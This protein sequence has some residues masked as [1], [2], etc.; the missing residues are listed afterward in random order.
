MAI[1]RPFRGLRPRPEMAQEVASPPYDVLSTEEARQIARNNRNSFLRV[2]KAELEFNGETD[3]YSESVYRRSKE[4]LMRLCNDGI[5]IRD[6]TPSFYTYRLTMNNRRQTG[7]VAL[8]S[9]DEYDHGKIKKHEHTRPEKVRDRARHMEYLEA[10]VGPVLTTFKY[11][12]KIDFIFKR[13]TTPSALTDF[14][15]DDNVRHELWVVN[16]PA[17][18]DEII[19]A[20]ADVPEIYIADGHHRSAS[21]SEVRRRLQEKNADHRGDEIYNFFLTVNFPDQELNILPYN[22]VVKNLNDLTIEQ[23]LQKTSEKFDVSRADSE[24]RPENPHEFGVYCGGQWFLLKARPGSFDESS[25]AG[26]IDASILATNLITPILGIDNP[27]TDPRIDFV[28]GIRGTAEL[29]KRVDSG[30]YKIAFSLYPTSIGQLLSV[31]DAGEVMPPKSTWFEPKLRSGM[32]VNM[33]TE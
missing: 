5:M 24:I 13:I 14:V 8:A 6:K 28:G 31:A 12:K 23:F 7:L 27:K 22:R 30:E 33:L 18:I 20:F 3:P 9:V 4:N 19:A 1:V 16:D 17:I 11:N 10:Q 32:V 21:A 15:A 25:P 2:N 26:P 29:V